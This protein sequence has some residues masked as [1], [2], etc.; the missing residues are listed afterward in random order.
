MLFGSIT[1]LIVALYV[2]S[3]LF[4]HAYP[5]HT[6]WAFCNAD[7]PPNAFMVVDRQPAVMDDLVI[8]LRE[9]LGVVLLAVV[10]WW[11]ARRLRTASPLQRRANAP[12]VVMSLAWLATLVAYL[13]TR[14]A[15]PDSAGVDTLGAHLEPVYPRHRGRLP[16][17]DGA[18]ARR[19]GR[20]ALRL[21]GQSSAA[22]ATPPSFAPRS[23][24]SCAIATSTSSCPPPGAAGTTA[25]G[26]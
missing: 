21:R 6:P 12:V 3:A 7:C 14:R 23:R 20:A 5:L 17:R 15:A 25:R 2:G 9:L 11:L 24:S 13:V 26:A 1:G 4:V 10:T 8:P 19:A 16:R 22:R 18:T